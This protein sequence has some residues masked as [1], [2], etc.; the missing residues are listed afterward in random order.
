MPANQ[1]SCD[2]AWLEPS[3][4]TS[5]SGRG[6]WHLSV[7]AQG[8]L[9]C[10]SAKQTLL[11]ATAVAIAWWALCSQILGTWAVDGLWLVQKGRFR[12][13][14]RKLMSRRSCLKG[15]VIRRGSETWGK[16]EK[17]VVIWSF[18][19]TLD[20][21]LTLC[22]KAP[23]SFFFQITK[24]LLG[25]HI[26]LGTFHLC[27]GQARWPKSLPQYKSQRLPS[28]PHFPEGK[29]FGTQWDFWVDQHR[30]VL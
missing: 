7:E 16:G 20:L 23:P 10:Y 6:S 25:P 8:C 28:Y 17:Q 2:G 5:A 21:N 11:P 9:C 27:Q 22:L 12:V 3:Q 18:W 1:H 13:L 26:G 30:I 29:P 4:N 15:Q 19:T 24:Q 14:Q